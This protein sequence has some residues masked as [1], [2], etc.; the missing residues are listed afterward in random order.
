MTIDDVPRLRFGYLPTPLDEAPRLA[1]KLGIRRLLIKRDDLTGLAL[2]GNK[3]RKIEFLM[4][5]ALEHK[6]DVIL[7]DGGPQS[8]H[9]RQTAA[10]A[11][12]FGLECIL[13]LGGPRFD[14]FEGNLL[15]DVILGAE[16]RFIPDATVGM[17][18][19]AMV[20]AAEELRQA[21][22]KPYVIPIGGSSPTGA[23]G[24]V[25][26]IRELAEQLGDD[27]EPQIVHAVGSGGTLAGCLLGTRLY[28]PGARIIGISVGR[29]SKPFQKIAA[30]LAERAA[31][32]MGKHEQ[33]NAEEVE[34][35]DDYLGQ[36]YAVPTEAGIQGILL[37]ARTEALILDPVYTGKAMSGL[38]D[39]AEKG[40]IDP[41]RTTVFLHTGGAPGLFAYEEHFTKFARYSELPNL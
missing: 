4:A 38:V 24:Y 19:R 29:A 1:E 31:E 16:I 18:E 21:G 32:I 25:A 17:M 6:A 3:V 26:A 7:T 35:F 37:A 39:L 41:D 28:L 15:L 36:R 5:D 30:D 11:R 27:R 8:N 9:A 20:K 12:L 14:R 40:I 23:L 33:F 10:A 22:R 13:H 34:V 2:G